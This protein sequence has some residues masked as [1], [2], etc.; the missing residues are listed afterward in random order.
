MK[1]RFALKAFVLTLMAS[2]LFFTS[3]KDEETISFSSSDNNDLQSEAS[4]DAQLE[5]VSDL[6]G[7]AVASDAGTLT[8][9]RSAGSSRVITPA[10]DTRF[11]CAT[12]TLE[13]AADNNPPSVIHGY[14]HIDFGTGCTG[15]N[16]RVRKGMIH[17][18]FNGPRFMPGSTVTITTENY[19]V[20]GIKID[21]TRTE[22]NASGST[23]D[24][25][26]F[27]ITEE[28]TVTFL[29]GTTATRTA[30][31]TRTWNRMANPLEDSW[32]VTGSAFGTTRRG[33]EYVMTIT[34][35]LVFKRSCAISSKMVVPVEGTKELVTGTKKIVTDFGNG[36]CDTTITITV[37]GRS[38]DIQISA[39][40]D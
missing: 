25:P 12:V 38:K 11:S 21:G 37:N 13:F 18:E 3:C 29:D 7:V 9:A 8:G 2:F 10:G 4:M 36:D 6:A 16:G 34:K 28:V 15:P 5:D 33:V 39:N 24:A 35:A 40:G 23:Q 22:L 14:I 32:T 27:T 20:D 1:T 31:R 19:Y 26:K 17:V 30:T